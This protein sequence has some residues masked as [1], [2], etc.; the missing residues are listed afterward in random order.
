MKHERID[1][2]T[3]ILSSP[4]EV[5][6]DEWNALLAGDAQPT[7]FL[8]HEFLD[9]LH[10][11]RCAVDDTGW[12]PHFVTLTDARTGRLAAAAPVYAKQHSY[13]EYVFDWAWAD[14]YQRND[15]PYYPKLLCAVPF[16]PVQGTRLLAADDDARRRLAATLLAFAEQSDVSS[17]HVLFPTG[18]EARLLES[19]GMMLR[20][21]VQFHWLNDGYRHFDD[22]LGTLE[23]KKR[24]N[25]RAE[26][27]KVHDAGV[28]FRR[29][30]GDQ[31]TDAD[32]RFFSRCYRQTYRE[33]YSSPYLNL[34]FFRTIGATMP[35]NLLLVIAEADGRPIASAL[36]VYR[37]G[38]HGGG[39]LY[40]RYWG[41]IE[42]VPCLHFE[43]AYYQL[44]EF[45]IEAGLDTFE[46]GAQGEHKLA[47]GFLPTVTHSAHWLAH[48][49]FS[50]AVARFLERETEHIHAYVDELREHDPFR[51]NTG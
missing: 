11:A 20:E 29:L 36:A 13:G 9:A 41:A 44:L 30:T 17:L 51:R 33:H 46:G 42:H 4:A 40:G 26:R 39:T 6:A 8:R 32:W 23:Q 50:D 5:P 2:R 15:L 47:R 22:F 1:Y 3:G 37:R 45:C 31:I 38:E 16:T 12:S 34:D 25:I 28:T 19:M 10:V 14:A 18:D 21:G 48:P 35:E 7:P 43:T 24:K 27:R 49:A